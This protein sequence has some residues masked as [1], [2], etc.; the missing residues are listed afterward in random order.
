MRIRF[1]S[2]FL[3]LFFLNF[4]AQISGKFYPVFR[5]VDGDTFVILAENSTKLKIRFIGIDAP[6]SRN[7]GKKK[8]VEI[9]GIEAKAHLQKYLS[10]KKVRLEF[11]IQ[12]ID[13][14]GRT[15]AYV[16]L[17]NGVFVNN[18]LVKKGYARVATFPPN[19]RFVHQFRKAEAKARANKLGLWKHY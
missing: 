2:F 9:F 6:E 3:F 18:D 4:N 10:R 11:D 15:L 5:V 1:Y 8:R 17:E 14:Y 12:K 13:R 19:V 7:V 16:Y